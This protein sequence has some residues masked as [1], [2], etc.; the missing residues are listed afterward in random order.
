MVYL[1]QKK[2]KNEFTLHVCFQEIFILSKVGHW[3]FQGGGGSS[4]TYI[5]KEIM[6][7]NWNF[8]RDGGGFQRGGGW[9]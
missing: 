1:L 2:K 3:N 4:K 6:K 8:Q 9:V 7:L 5:L